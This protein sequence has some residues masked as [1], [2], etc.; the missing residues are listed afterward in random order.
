MT[1][2][3][4]FRLAHGV[5]DRVFLEVEIF[6]DV[7][8]S[9]N[10]SLFSSQYLVF[11]SIMASPGIRRGTCGHAMALFDLHTKCARCREKGV[12]T[13]PCVEKKPC[14]ICDGFTSE[15]KKQLATPTYR[16]EHQKKARSPPPPPPPPHLVDPASELL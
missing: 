2:L 15:Q 1:S 14:E 12:G 11:K 3:C 5:C 8:P 7:Q 13:D 6:K 9:F 4:L 16:K 10:F